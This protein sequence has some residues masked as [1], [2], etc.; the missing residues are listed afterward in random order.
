M[1][2][3]ICDLG[4]LPAHISNSRLGRDVIFLLSWHGVGVNTSFLVQKVECTERDILVSSHLFYSQWN[5][6]IIVA[7][8]HTH[9]RLGDFMA[10][11]SF[12]LDRT[13]FIRFVDRQ[14]V[15]YLSVPCCFWLGQQMVIPSP[16][17][18]KSI[19]VGGNILAIV[20]VIMPVLVFLFSCGLCWFGAS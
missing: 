19:I 18:P 15:F 17:I 6:F 2:V 3:L 10:L 16:A 1:L 9:Y 5:S 4:V 8:H 11:N 13:S 14:T 20:E 12:K 7:I